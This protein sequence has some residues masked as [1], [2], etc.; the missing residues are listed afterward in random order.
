[1][2]TDTDRLNILDVVTRADD[3]ATR[4]DSDAY[5]AFFT[6][7]AVLD[8]DKGEHR[9]RERL[10]QS[11]GPIWESEGP[12]STHCSLN[13]VVEGVEGDP[14]GAIVTSLL[15]ILRNNET[16]VA[17]AN[18]SFITQHLVRTGSRWLIDHRSVRSRPA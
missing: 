11:V 7:D 12:M 5:V 1:M 18:L 15:M 6:D 14:D 4:R 10:R 13:A 17:I 9:G 2:L 3:A 16:P 8:G